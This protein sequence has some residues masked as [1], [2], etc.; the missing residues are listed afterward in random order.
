[1]FPYSSSY[2]N[3]GGMKGYI[4]A[5]PLISDIPSDRNWS[6]ATYGALHELSSVNF[7][8]VMLTHDC[9]FT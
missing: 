6:S 2:T 5:L 7:L 4:H 9:L 8:I 3:H 1:M